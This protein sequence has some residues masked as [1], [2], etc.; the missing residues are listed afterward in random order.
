LDALV[1]SYAP[2]PLRKT[3]PLGRKPEIDGALK[4]TPTGLFAALA[5]TTS[6]RTVAP[7]TTSVARETLMVVRDIGSPSFVDLGRS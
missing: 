1:G 7:R 5:G 6:A 4:P 2:P 3:S